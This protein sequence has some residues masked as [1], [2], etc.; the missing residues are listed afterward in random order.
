LLH[1]AA[2]LVPLPRARRADAGMPPRAAATVVH[3]VIPAWPAGPQPRR[4]EPGPVERVQETRPT[5]PVAPPDITLEPVHGTEVDLTPEPPP[6]E[7]EMVLAVP[8]PPPSGPE[9]ED[10]GD[11]RPPALKTESRVEPVYPPAARR[12]GVPGNAVLRV[13]VLPSGDVGDIVPLRCVPENLGFCEAAS[14]AVRRWRYE[15]G[16][17]GERAL[18]MSVTV[19]VIFEVPR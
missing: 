6:V 5:S 7:V 18:Q 4:L 14:E 15:P 16:R 3:A 2:V 8:E 19:N 17:L 11:V 13:E 10:L 1:V 9:P 12:L